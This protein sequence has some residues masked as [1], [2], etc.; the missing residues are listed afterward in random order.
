MNT[1]ICNDFEKNVFILINT[2]MFGKA[3]ENV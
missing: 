1:D 3:M 2:S